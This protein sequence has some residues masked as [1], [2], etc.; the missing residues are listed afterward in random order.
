VGGRDAHFHILL[1]HV[2]PRWRGRGG[3]VSGRTQAFCTV[4]IGMYISVELVLLCAAGGR[5]WAAAQFPVQV[6]WSAERS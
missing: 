1:R 5:V 4:F 6:V 3:E 2:E